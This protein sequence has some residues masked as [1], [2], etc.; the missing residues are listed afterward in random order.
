[1]N[2]NEPTEAVL[3]VI[4]GGAG[5]LTW[6]KVIPALFDLSQDR[7]MPPYLTI[8]AVDRRD[9]DTDTLR[10]RLH[11]GV[12]MFSRRGTIDDEKWN[13][14]ARHIYYQQG[15]F[16][17][18]ETYAAIKTQS[19]KCEK[20]WKTKPQ[21][22]FY[23][24][25]PPSFFGE[26]AKC[27]EQVGLAKDETRERIV[28]EK[29][30]GYDL[31]SAQKLNEVFEANFH[32]CQI[33][34]IDHYLG[35]ETVQNILAFRFANPLFEP[36]W[37][38]RYVEYVTITVAENIGIEHRG[39][40]YENAGAL[41]D[42]VQNHLLQLLCLIAM[43]PMVSFKADEIRNKKV[44]VLH[45]IRPIPPHAVRDYAVRG[46]YGRGRIDQDEVPGYREEGGVAPDSETET[47]VALKL[48]VDNWRWQGV[49]FYVRTGKRMPRQASEVVIQFRAV[50][51]QSFPPEAAAHWQ[52]AHIIMSIQPDE[53]IVLRF[54]AKQPGP[55]LVLKPVDMR[56]NY[57]ESF[58]GPFPDAY[59]TLLW[60]V[61]NNDPTLFMRADQVEAA[62]RILTP[63]LDAWKREKP[64][65]FPNYPAGSWGPSIANALFTQ[66]GHCWPM[67]LEKPDYCR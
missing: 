33:F 21:I 36:I 17:R 34:R 52:N 51:H 42:M 23:M 22:I 30:I 58:S 5:D 13:E 9:M 11:Q 43:E 46:Q 50:P 40:Y 66:E 12:N 3:F 7:H 45:A 48:F 10:E 44:D 2:A 64:K 57:R 1:M 65:D 53:T 47:F 55:K 62:W 54:Q 8:I 15:D 35:K 63:I 61:M 39:K 18:I 20:E 59:E 26:I 38:R 56:F 67:P 49:P 27:L 4:F 16:D 25:T 14:F 41:R 6:R 29:P 37:N 60:D 32:E 19:D 24:A 28:V 31:E